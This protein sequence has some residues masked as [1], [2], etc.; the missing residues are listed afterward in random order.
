[1]EGDKINFKEGFS[2]GCTLRTIPFANG[3]FVKKELLDYFPPAPIKP[4]SPA[5]DIWL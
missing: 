2:E 3:P 5:A 4:L 1:M